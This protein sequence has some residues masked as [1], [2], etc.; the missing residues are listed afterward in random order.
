MDTRVSND[1]PRQLA[2]DLLGEVLHGPF[3]DRR[4]FSE[5]GAGLLPTLADLSPE[6]ASLPVA[7]GRPSLA[8]FVSHLTQVLQDAPRALKG[9]E[10]RDEGQPDWS[11]AWSV[12]TVNDLGWTRMR[13]GLS[14]AAELLDA[15]LA[16]Q[17]DLSAAQTRAV[18]TAVTHAAYH[19]GAIRFAARNLRAE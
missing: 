9:D 11:V 15:A 7:R 2:R 13:E 17:A 4:L 12:T 18:F 5:D 3:R 16:D 10:G 14:E 1:D 19:A 6:E 8:A